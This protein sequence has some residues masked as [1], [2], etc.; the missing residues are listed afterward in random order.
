MRGCVQKFFYIN[1]DDLK[2]L[3]VRLLMKTLR[4]RIGRLNSLLILFL[5]ITGCQSSD[6]K[7]NVGQ[8]GEG[9]KTAEQGIVE[10]K[11]IEYIE[12]LKEFES[13]Q[14]LIELFGANNVKKSFLWKEEGAVKYP[15]S[16]IFPESGHPLK[17]FW[18]PDQDEYKGIK[19]V[20]LEKLIINDEDYSIR[21][22]DDDYWKF[23]NGLKL[24]MTIE[25]VEKLI[26][27]GFNFYGLDW[28]YGGTI[29]TDNKLF[30]NYKLF[31]G[32]VRKDAD[33]VPQDYDKIIG[34][35]E[36]T[37][38]NSIARTLPLKMVKIVYYF[39]E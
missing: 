1:T 10:E 26:G 16:V 32:F 6:N 19:F 27:G 34:D 30:K 12:A 13:H 8:K 35:I 7:E 20:E 36:F 38:D 28:D 24:G 15:V 31:L 33:K 25:E 17:V 3:K 5:F 39:E 18:Q 23:K 29:I 11:T 21:I 22:A 4:I 2:E 9:V 37:S 14:S